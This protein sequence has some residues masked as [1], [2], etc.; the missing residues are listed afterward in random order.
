M[1]K[2]LKLKTSK[3]KPLIQI[4]HW[5]FIIIRR[6]VNRSR[7]TFEAGL[8]LEHPAGFPL[9][10]IF[11]KDSSV[12]TLQRCL[13]GVRWIQPRSVTDLLDTQWQ[14]VHKLCESQRIFWS[15][16]ESGYIS[17]G[18]TTSQTSL[19]RLDYTLDYTRPPMSFPPWTLLQSVT[20]ASAGN[21]HK[22]HDFTSRFKFE[23]FVSKN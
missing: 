10:E 2:A 3:P 5:W 21:A 8:V 6:F 9:R 7:Y 14:M 12:K 23:T 11:T 19:S 16:P 1:I 20:P 17:L 18:I 22:W 4:T 15:R 13:L